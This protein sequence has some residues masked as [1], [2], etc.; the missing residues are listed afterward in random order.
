LGA[1]LGGLPGLGLGV[2]GGVVLGVVLLV[3][4]SGDH[5]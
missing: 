4:L 5:N 2:A 1:E 3:F